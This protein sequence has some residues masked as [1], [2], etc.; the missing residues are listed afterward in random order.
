MTRQ[1][2][3]PLAL[4]MGD[5]AGI[6]LEIALKAWLQREHAQHCRRSASTAIATRSSARADAFG[7]DVADCR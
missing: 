6:G 4:T 2:L 1:R 7:L 3:A 5:P